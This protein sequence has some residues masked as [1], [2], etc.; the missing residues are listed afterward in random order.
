MIL[1]GKALYIEVDFLCNSNKTQFFS[2][3]QI[4]KA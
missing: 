2:N 3:F 4:E 1:K